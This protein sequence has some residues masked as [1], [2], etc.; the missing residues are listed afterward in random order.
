MAD[1][2]TTIPF[3][4]QYPNKGELELGLNPEAVAASANFSNR[5]ELPEDLGYF[6]A[7][8]GGSY[9]P[10]NQDNRINR[11]AGFE[12]QNPNGFGANAGIDELMKSVGLNAGPVNAN[13]IRTDNDI[14]KSLGL[15]GDNFGANI[16]DSNEGTSY[17]VRGLLN[18]LG[19]E[20]SAEAYKDPND[21]GLM[22]NFN[23]TF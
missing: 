19:G 1:K 5:T 16:T 23:R 8:V 9:M 13:I 20:L 15:S 6:D 12:Y 11:R 22:I 14:I 21:K 4:D 3:Y 18:L 2:F 7:M 10:N 17:G